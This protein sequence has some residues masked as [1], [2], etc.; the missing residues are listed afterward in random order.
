MPDTFRIDIA[1][2]I[3]ALHEINPEHASDA[4]M[5]F[6]VIWEETNDDTA[7]TFVMD[8]ES[9]VGVDVIPHWPWERYVRARSALLNTGLLINDGEL[10]ALGHVPPLP[11][12]RTAPL[13]HGR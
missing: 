12:S 5:L 7:H 4:F 11:S 1:C 6:A 13:R 8:P 2:I 9:M 10:F 3:D